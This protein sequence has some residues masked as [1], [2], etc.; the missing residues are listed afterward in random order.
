MKMSYEFD[1]AVS[2]RP[3]VHTPQC[4]TAG[5]SEMW[6]GCLATDLAKVKIGKKV[7]GAKW[8]HEP[9]KWAMFAG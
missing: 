9:M 2:S 1:G 3:W 8:P 5:D 4:E 6:S 7:T